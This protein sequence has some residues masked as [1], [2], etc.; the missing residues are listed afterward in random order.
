MPAATSILIPS[1]THNL[2][3]Y[4][5]YSLI[6]LTL[7]LCFCLSAH[8]HMH[9]HKHKQN[10]LSLFSGMYV[11][12]CVCVC[13]VYILRADH[14]IW[15]NYQ[16]SDSQR[17]LIHFLSETTV[18]CFNSSVGASLHDFPYLCWHVSHGFHYADIV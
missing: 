11:F 14:L 3:S 5:N 17:I 2:F 4:F 15:K 6:S 7:C 8:R 18:A 9:K 1:Y 12:V 16:G 10:L 13:G